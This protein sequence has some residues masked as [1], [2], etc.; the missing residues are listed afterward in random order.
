[1]AVQDVLR[2]QVDSEFRPPID[3]GHCDGNPAFWHKF[4]ESFRLKVYFNP[5]SIKLIHIEWLLCV[6]EGKVKRSIK[7]IGI[8]GIFYAT[9][10]MILEPDVNNK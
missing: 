5:S 2:Q 6:L 8:N 7:S 10:L 1:M 3:L 9:M 4:I